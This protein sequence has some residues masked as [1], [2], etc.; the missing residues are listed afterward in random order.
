MHSNR[1]PCKVI[2]EESHPPPSPSN[3][4]KQRSFTP[5]PLKEEEK[6]VGLKRKK[7]RKKKLFGCSSFETFFLRQF[8]LKQK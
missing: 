7:D 1:P 6:K 2:H 3:R 5:Q 8:I 4:V